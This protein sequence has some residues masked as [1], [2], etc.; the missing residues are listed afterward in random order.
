MENGKGISIF[1]SIFNSSVI[2][3]IYALKVDP[4]PTAVAEAVG[5]QTPREN[6]SFWSELAKRPLCTEE[7]QKNPCYFLSFL[8]HR[9]DTIVG[10]ICQVTNV[11][12][13]IVQEIL[14]HSIN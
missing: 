2:S 14:D 7:C 12:E 10:F 5:T 1:L 8:S 9:I 4:S 6:P 3:I 11:A 13:Y